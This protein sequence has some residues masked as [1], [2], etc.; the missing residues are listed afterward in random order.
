MSRQPYAQLEMTPLY[1]ISHALL[2]IAYD[3]C[4]RG[5]IAGVENLNLPGGYIVASN[6][7]SFADPPIVG[8]FLPRQVNFFARKSLWKPG[9][10]ARWLDGV[11]TIPVDRDGGADTQAIKRVLQSL[12]SGRVV[13]LFPEGTRSPDDQLQKPKPGIGLIACRSGVPVV[14][15]RVFGAFEAFGRQSGPR[16]GT[17]IS[18][19][20]GRPLP[21][22]DYDDPNSGKDRYRVAAERIMAAIARL[23]PPKIE[24]I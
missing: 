16:L 10:A 14:P 6:H 24:V 17:P 21:P 20:Y 12:E 23:Q 9:L 5:D 11:G 3:I 18:V 22:A 19:T 7:A 2:E 1:G 8:L 4:F 15:A 13:I